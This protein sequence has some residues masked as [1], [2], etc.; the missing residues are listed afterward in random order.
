MNLK[1][2]RRI[3]ALPYF[4]RAGAKS[5]RKTGTFCIFIIR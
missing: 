5:P 4:Y 3:R 1:L 2:I